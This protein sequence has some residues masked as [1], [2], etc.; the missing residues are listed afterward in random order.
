M[1]RGRM[2]GQQAKGRLGKARLPGPLRYRGAS[3]LGLTG[4]TSPHAPCLL[5]YR[6]GKAAG[7]VAPG[8]RCAPMVWRLAGVQVWTLPAPPLALRPPA[9]GRLAPRYNGHGGLV[10]LALPL[11]AAYSH[12]L[13]YHLRLSVARRLIPRGGA[14]EVYAS[15][16]GQGGRGLPPPVPHGSRV[17]LEVCRF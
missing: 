11:P 12:T 9:Q 5:P 8:G 13:S 7:D 16:S 17:G 6:V 4:A 2:P 1:P 10:G 15:S 3:P 14:D